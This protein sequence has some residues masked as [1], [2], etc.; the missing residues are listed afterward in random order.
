MRYSIAEIMQLAGENGLVTSAVRLNADEVIRELERGRPVMLPIRLPSIYVQQRVLPGDDAPI[1]GVVRNS[2]IYRAGRVSEFTN[3]AMVDHY[4]LAV[5]YDEDQFVVIE[6]VMGYR[7]ISAA[8]LARYRQA[9][10]DAAVVFSAQ[11]EAAPEA[12]TRG[13]APFSVAAALLLAEARG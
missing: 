9:F 11:P 4:V 12:S 8:T 7:T 3:L 5:G 1:V 6:P 13:L 2:L 10:G